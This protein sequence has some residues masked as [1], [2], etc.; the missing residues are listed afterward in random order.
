MSGALRHRGPDDGGDVF[1]PAAGS[2]VGLA[3]RRL[4]I[5]D[6]TAA[7]HQPMTLRCPVCCDA[8]APDAERIWISFNGE[9][10]N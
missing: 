8:D 3:T 1:F 7:G 5:L 10:Y 6:L 9:I 4:A 2:R